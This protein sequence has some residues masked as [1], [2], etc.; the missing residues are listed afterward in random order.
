M[1]T[2]TRDWPI[3]AKKSQK[4]GVKS[5]KSNVNVTHGTENKDPYYYCWS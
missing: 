5:Q 1:K 2:N 3:V 4:S